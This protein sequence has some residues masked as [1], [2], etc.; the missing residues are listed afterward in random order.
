MTPEIVIAQ[1]IDPNNKS[2]PQFRKYCTD[3]HKSNHSISNCFRK[4]RQ[5]EERKRNSFSRSKSPTKS[6]NQH[7]KAYKDQILPNEQPIA[8][9]INYLSRI[10]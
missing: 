7:F 8:F 10:N 2:K 9:S 5:D 1:N 4:Q 6:I 3:C